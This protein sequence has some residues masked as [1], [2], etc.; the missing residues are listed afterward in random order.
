MIETTTDHKYD[1]VF[2]GGN[3]VHSPLPREIVR[4]GWTDMPPHEMQS[5]AVALT[6]EIHRH[7][8]SYDD[9]V[10]EQIESAVAWLEYWAGHGYS[11]TAEW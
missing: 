1:T 9:A 4:D 7:S 3:I 11:I 5:Y 6:G 2:R 10:T 8:D